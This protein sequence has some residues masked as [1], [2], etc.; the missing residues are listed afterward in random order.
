MKVSPSVIV[1]AD[2]DNHIEVFEQL[3][4]L[5]EVFGHE[6]C[7]RCGCTDL[8]FVVREN[9]NEDKFYELRCTN[10]ECRAILGFGCNKKGKSLYPYRKENEKGTIMGL[11]PGTYLPHSGWLRYNPETKK[12]W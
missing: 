7:S 4:R 5:Q 8:R 6:K 3:S 9:D 1:V 10:T 12:K 11:K 2:G